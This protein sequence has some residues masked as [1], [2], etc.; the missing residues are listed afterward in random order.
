MHN[1]NNRLALHLGHLSKA[2]LAWV[3]RNACRLLFTLTTKHTGNG[4]VKYHVIQPDQAIKNINISRNKIV[5]D[6]ARSGHFV[7]VLYELL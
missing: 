7:L 2:R 6:E 4:G 5:T 1:N 3:Q